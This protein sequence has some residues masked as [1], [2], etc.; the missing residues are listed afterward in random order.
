MEKV[1]EE[2]TRL[3]T[4]MEKMASEFD[5]HAARTA[6]LAALQEI[7]SISTSIDDRIDKRLRTALI[8][9]SVLLALFSAMG[10]LGLQTTLP[11]VVEA[12][13]G[14]SAK[15]ELEELR[16]YAAS[17][18]EEIRAAHDAV[19]SPALIVLL[20]DYGPEGPYMGALIGKIYQVNPHAQVTV[21]TSIHV[22]INKGTYRVNKKAASRSE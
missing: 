19:Q 9:V 20:T 1:Q 6:R 16:A 17:A 2:V 22:R 11:K 7:Q 5:Q 8:F 10:Y 4:R 12:A 13:L 21:A 3:A 15:Q 18:V 14:T